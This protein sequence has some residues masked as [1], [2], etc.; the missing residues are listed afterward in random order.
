MT[1]SQNFAK[2]PLTSLS[3]RHHSLEY[4]AAFGSKLPDVQAFLKLKA[5]IYDS[6]FVLYHVTSR[7]ETPDWIM[8]YFT[9]KH[10]AI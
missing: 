4:V 5:S 1:H 2:L 8:F 9:M 10:H 6:E 7:Y 3:F